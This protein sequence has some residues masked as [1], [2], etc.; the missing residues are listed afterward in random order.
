M[1][2]NNSEI[3][4]VTYP[5]LNKFERITHFTSTRQGG[6]SSG[7]YASL[8]LGRFSGDEAEKIQENFR[9]LL[10]TIG[11]KDEQ[12]HLPYQTHEDIVFNIDEDFLSLDKTARKEKLHGVDAL[13]TNVPNQCIGVS[14]ADCVPI[15]IYDPAKQAI[16]TAHSGWRGTCSRIVKKTVQGMVENFQSN[17]ADLIVAIGPSIS[18]D[19]YEVGDELIDHFQKENFDI[20]KIFFKQ[21]EKY[22][23]DLWEANKLTLMEV[24]VLEENI[25]ISGY[26]TYTEHQRFF[27]ARRLGIKSGRLVSGLMIVE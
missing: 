18:P 10:Q 19:V 2:R 4:L 16:G 21:G 13:I 26:C 14:T 17:P 8:N 3:D 20:E 22:H 6:V 23:L 27:S 7:N 24:G 11:I 1:I 9:R 5:I 25:E 12:I 15:L